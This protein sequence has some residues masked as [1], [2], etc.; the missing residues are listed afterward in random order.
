M[1]AVLALG[2]ILLGIFVWFLLFTGK[3]QIPFGSS[4]NG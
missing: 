3:I 1:E 4:T 2:L